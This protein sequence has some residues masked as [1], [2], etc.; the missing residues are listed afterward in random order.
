MKTKTD[1]R[2]G[3]TF[4]E[5]DAQ[6][7]YWKSMAQSGYCYGYQPYPPTPYPPAPYPPAPAPVPSGSCPSAW[8]PGTVRESSGGGVY[9]S[10]LGQ[11]NLV[12]YF[13][14]GYTQFYPNG[15]GVSVGQHVSYAPFPA[16]NERAGK[17]ACI[18]SGY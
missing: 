8:Y 7:N 9:G 10:I 17:A 6:R 18:S 13:N 1:I 3:M 2:A 14:A 11:D 15:Q 5:C 16:G 4:E 12:H